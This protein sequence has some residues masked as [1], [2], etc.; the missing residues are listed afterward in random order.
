MLNRDVRAR[1]WAPPQAKPRHSLVRRWE[2]GFDGEGRG[3]LSVD[4][5]GRDGLNYPCCA[6]KYCFFPIR[7][8]SARSILFSGRGRRGVTRKG[9]ATRARAKE[10]AHRAKATR[11]PWR[12]AAGRH[13]ETHVRRAHHHES[14]AVI[15]FFS[16]ILFVVRG[17]SMCLIDIYAT[18]LCSVATR[19]P[20]WGR[21]PAIVRDVGSS[22]PAPFVRQS[23][24][25]W[26]SFR[27]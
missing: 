19:S 9:V 14:T 7:N 2:A 3:R 13:T 27:L 25:T 23:R 20:L 6:R 17:N 21:T 22:C 4:K 1:R 10:R 11:R 8:A 24:K 15:V 18:G 16:L 12:T 26:R 5:P